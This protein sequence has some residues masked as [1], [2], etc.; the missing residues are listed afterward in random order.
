MRI[1]DWS[2]DVC[3]SDLARSLHRVN[4]RGTPTA[5]PVATA[6]PAEVA[7]EATAVAA[8]GTAERKNAADIDA[9]PEE[10]EEA[11]TLSGASNVAAIEAAPPDEHPNAPREKD[12]AERNPHNATAERQDGAP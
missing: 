6:I 4:G 9:W 8:G 2:S 1:S 12:P 5:A 10:R 7:A 11:Q 3:S